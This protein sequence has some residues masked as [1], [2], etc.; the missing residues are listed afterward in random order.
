MKN[1]PSSSRLEAKIQVTIKLEDKVQTYKINSSYFNLR[2][3]SSFEDCPINFCCSN[4]HCGACLIRVVDGLSNFNL[5]DSIEKSFLD[6][7]GAGSDERLACR[8]QITG[9]VTIEPVMV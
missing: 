8:S 3:L 4:C 2:D 7:L 6:S 1:T 9:S 5:P